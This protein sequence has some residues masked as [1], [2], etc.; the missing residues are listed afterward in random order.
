M[1]KERLNR[2]K[3]MFILAAM[4]SVVA[5]I[6]TALVF[7]AANRSAAGA[8]FMPMVLCDLVAAF[9]WCSFV[10]LLL[11]ALPV[12][13]GKEKVY[14]VEVVNKEKSEDKNGDAN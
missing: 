11:Q 7:I 13:D 5:L 6:L 10:S 1:D 9:L 4:V 2:A 3:N 12:N 8:L 14:K